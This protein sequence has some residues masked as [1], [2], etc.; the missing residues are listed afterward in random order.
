M[1]GYNSAKARKEF[2]NGNGYGMY[3]SD[4]NNSSVNTKTTTA[5]INAGAS[6]VTFTIPTIKATLRYKD[7]YINI[8]IFDNAGNSY[9]FSVLYEFDTTAP[10]KVG[11]TGP[12][13]TGPNVDG[14][15]TV[16]NNQDTIVYT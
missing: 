6:N 13:I 1:S 14:S 15:N 8:R 5:N 4:G 11:S 3:N 10:I 12:V 7:W 9:V 2:D 16:A